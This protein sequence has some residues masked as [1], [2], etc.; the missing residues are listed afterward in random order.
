MIDQ[1]LGA[2]ILK[3]SQ[4]LGSLCPKAVRTRKDC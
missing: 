2:R 1:D 3:S 4:S